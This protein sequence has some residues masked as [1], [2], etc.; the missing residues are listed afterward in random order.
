[1]E[2]ITQKNDMGLTLD[3]LRTFIDNCKELPGTTPIV[4]EYSETD[5]KRAMDIQGDENDITIYNW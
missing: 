4:I 2:V 3:D 1:M 5:S